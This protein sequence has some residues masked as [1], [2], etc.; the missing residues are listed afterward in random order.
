MA[1]RIGI[2]F[3][4]D[5]GHARG[6][7]NDALAVTAVLDEVRA[8]ELAC[9]SSGFDSVQIPATRDIGKLVAALEKA[10]PDV[11]FNLAEALGGESQL[12]AGVAFLLDLLGVVYT[13]S[14]PLTLAAALD[15]PLAKALLH[16]RSVPTPR[17]W[18]LDRGDEPLEA[19]PAV[20]IVKPAREDA[21][22][23]IS[24]DSVVRSPEAARARAR[25]LI[26]KYGQ[27]ALIEEFVEGREFN[28][29]L[30]G[31]GRSTQVLA[32]TEIDFSGFP[33]GKPRL[34]TYA[35]KWQPDSPEYQGSPSIA[36]REVS[37]AVAD[38]IRAAALAAYTALGVRDY[39]R[40]DIR[41]AADDTPLVL[42]VNPNPDLSP[43]AGLARAAARSGISYDRLIASIVYSARARCDHASAA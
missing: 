24:L 12:E 10:R 28:V 43:D 21:S 39:G 5:S 25:Y 30:L 16:Q 4:D 15:K 29:S 3:N 2:L 9:R 26:E 1:L 17:S 32:L 13:G 35:A 7:T 31:D 42:D 37:P 40:I 19:L 14:P 38:R 41:L 20:C 27:P 6:E 8:V 36:A 11:V 23:G 33:A 34:V 22:H 18:V